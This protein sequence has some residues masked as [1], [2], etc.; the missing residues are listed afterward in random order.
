MRRRLRG[1][2]AKAAS[3][4]DRPYAGTALYALAA[5]G[6]AS[7]PATAELKRL[8]VSL[9]GPDADRAARMAAMQL[10]GERGWREA[11]PA[12]RAALSGTDRDAAV[13]IVAIGTLGLIGDGSDSAL[14]EKV[15]ANGGVRLRTAA[16]TALRRIAGREHG[17]DSPE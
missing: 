2:F 16:E 7:P 5:D 3:R 11:L 13:D 12:V 15:L 9:C 6:R 17:S 4:K 8:T 14:V 1:I 10:A